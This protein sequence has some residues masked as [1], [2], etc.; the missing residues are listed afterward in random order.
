MVSVIVPVYN[1]ENYIDRCL[2]SI[3]N[4]T[5]KNIEILIMEAKSTDNSLYRCID[6]AKKD[7]RITIVSRKDG[8]LGPGRNF[9]LNI[10]KGKYVVFVDSDDWI[11]ENF[12]EKMVEM[13]NNDDKIDI[14]QSDVIIYAGNKQKNKKNL[15][16]NV[17]YENEDEKKLLMCYGDNSAWGK[18][19]KTDLFKKYEIKQPRLPFED[20]SV[21]PVLVAASKKVVTCHEATVFYQAEREGSLFQASDGYKKFPLVMDYA[22]KQLQRIG[23][24][25]QY[26]KAFLFMM[27]RH[28]YMTTCHCI[29]YEG[30]KNLRQRSIEMDEFRNKIFSDFVNVSYWAL[31]SFPLRWICHR[32][33]DGKQKLK[34]HKTFTGII[35][36]MTRGISHN[37]YNEN[38]FRNMCVQDDFYGWIIDKEL[39]VPNILLVDFMLECENVLLL[40]DDNYVTKSE[41]LDEAREADLINVRRVISWEEDEFWSLWKEKCLLFIDMLKSNY[42]STKIVIVENYLAYSYIVDGKRRNYP[43]VNTIEKKN[44]LISKMYDFFTSSMSETITITYDG[45]KKYTD[46]IKQKYNNFPYYLNAEYYDDIAKKISMKLYM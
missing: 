29:G 1:V 9:G 38:P 32:L 11:S 31:G 8:G 40:N 18:L 27:Y 7:N 2:H 17:S 10:A 26:K 37:V 28:F 46:V 23:A 45:D 4:Q 34:V 43:D 16:P 33:V 41:A 24:Y 44:K 19:Y 3:V 20:L 13:A 35:A 36:Q 30:Y 21:F 6:W 25:E 42:S 12:I 15:Q 22:K 39:D 5:Y 14:V